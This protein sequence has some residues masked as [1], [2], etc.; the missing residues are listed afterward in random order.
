MKKRGYLLWSALA[1]LVWLLG[2][3][4]S[5]GPQQTASE[6]RPPFH[7]G[8]TVDMVLR[9]NKWDAIN[10][11]K[12]NTRDE[13]GYLPLYARDD[14]GREVVR[15]NIPRNTAAVVVSRFYRDPPQ[16]AQL[17]QEWTAYLN[18][19]GF[20]R[21]VVLHA[22]PGTDIDGL[23]VLNDSTIAGVNVASINDE[24]PKVASAHAAVP[25]AAGANAA[26]P[27]SSSGR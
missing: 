25:A 6:I 5:V 3:C 12:P 23:P 22:G 26:N 15:R 21:V 2:S 1:S 4:A 13:G 24:Q 8:A 11:T 14:I 20:R 17:S 27:P 16:L 9:F 18:E 10:M 7:G 19:Q